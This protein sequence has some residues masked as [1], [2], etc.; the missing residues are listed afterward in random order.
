MKREKSILAPP[1]AASSVLWS[2]IG[3]IMWVLLVWIGDLI[4]HVVNTVEHIK[5][6]LKAAHILLGGLWLPIGLYSVWA[7]QPRRRHA[8][9]HR[10]FVAVLVVLYPSGMMFLFGTLLWGKLVTSSWHTMF[11]V[12]GWAL[13]FLSWTL[14]ALS[15]SLAE[16]LKKHQD[17]LDLLV[18]RWGGLGVVTLA[19]IIGASIGLHGGDERLWIMAFLSLILPVCWA[20]YAS[21]SLW[22]YRPWKKKEEDNERLDDTGWDH[23]RVGRHVAVAQ[24]KSKVMRRKMGWFRKTAQDYVLQGTEQSL[25]R[26]YAR[27]IKTLSKALELDPQEATAYLHRGIAYLESGEKEKALQ[28]FNQSLGL[29]PSALGYYNRALAWLEMGAEERALDDL[30]QAIRLA[31][32]DRE[33]YLLR[34]IVYSER[35]D[36]ERALEDVERAIELKHEGGKR[37]KAIILERAGWDEEALACWDEVLR[38]RGG[39]AIALARRGL[40][41]LRLGRREEAQRD[42]QRAWM[43]RSELGA[44]WVEKVKGALEELKGRG[45][46]VSGREN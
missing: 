1:P 25:R 7:W 20:Q 24:A 18:L 44:E 33:S 38:G 14:P 13:Y 15:F 16:W 23:R 34:G 30:G 19:G 4:I 3:S 35:G 29:E 9:W 28:D 26:E 11:E 43:K 40:L 31:P 17:S 10:W 37:A 36:Q 2:F 46:Y 8:W 6:P 22:P 21:S 5:W 39:D 42:L 27:A 32:K 12:I 41:L 45:E